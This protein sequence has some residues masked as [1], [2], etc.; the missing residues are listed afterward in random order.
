MFACAQSLS[1]LYSI[2]GGGGV[3]EGGEGREGRGGEVGTDR[4]VCLTFEV[5]YVSRKSDII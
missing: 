4:D 1:I 3:G 2:C 5:V